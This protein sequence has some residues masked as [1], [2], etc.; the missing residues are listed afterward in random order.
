MEV[1][2]RQRLISLLTDMGVTFKL[3]G[4]SVV[5]EEGSGYNGFFCAFEFDAEGKMKDYGCWE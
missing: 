3:D 2:A 1:S 5:I 4:D